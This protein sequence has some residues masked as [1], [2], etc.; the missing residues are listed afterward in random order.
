MKAASCCCARSARGW[1]ASSAPRTCCPGSELSDGDE[2]ND[3]ATQVARAMAE[4]FVV[5][6][7]WVSLDVPLGAVIY[8]GDGDDLENLVLHAD[9][10]MNRAREEDTRVVFWSRGHQLR[11]R[12]MQELL[13]S[14]D[15]AI[16]RGDF[17]VHFQPVF[18]ASD[19][20]LAGFES[21]LRWQH[22]DHGLVTPREFI[23]VLERSDK[24]HEIGAWVTEQTCR[25]L[26]RCRDEAGAH[27]RASINLSA[28]ELLHI[29]LPGR[30][31]EALERYGLPGR[32]LQVDIPEM[33]VADRLGA[34]EPAIEEIRALG[35]RV[36]LD[37][38]GRSPSTLDVL[39]SLRLDA[40]KLGESLTR[41]L[42]SSRRKG[43][44]I[45]AV[46]E[47]WHALGAEV[48][49]DAVEGKRDLA[50]LQRFGCDFVQG[51]LFGG[52]G[53]ADRIVELASRGR[54]KE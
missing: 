10:A 54:P 28:R 2:A 7:R 3:I 24:V 6:R 12:S 50:A 17:V 9:N 20:R 18:M 1:P 44:V 42:G 38:F 53:S 4:P 25:L 15:G 31:H 34:V 26:A 29:G 21:L 19:G 33:A 47:L 45:G 23:A 36:A 13:A 40:V 14:L 43:A 48:W 52:A 49:A 37:G 30:I 22:L 41:G 16:E 8:P 46:V 35:V 5:G 51:Y 32:M 27:L 11:F 39:Q